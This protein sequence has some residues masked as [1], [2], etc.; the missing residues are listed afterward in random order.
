MEN[1]ILLKTAPFGFDKKSV[2]DFIE[3]LQKKNEDL[4]R[5]NSRLMA[6][7]ESL[8]EAMFDF[9]AKK[10]EETIISKYTEEPVSKFESPSYE[11]YETT[12]SYEDLSI[13][14]EDL[15][16]ADK[17]T[18]KKLEEKFKL[19]FE[20][21]SKVHDDVDLKTISNSKNKVEKRKPTK[22]ITKTAP[23]KVSVQK[24]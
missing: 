10:E 5:E 14:A 22:I 4:R 3:N 18:R 7:N 23:K 1:D 24:R 15:E 16:M 17:E 11:G 19:A 8:R 21:V 2:M 20:E 9:T 12:Y 6:E 13:R